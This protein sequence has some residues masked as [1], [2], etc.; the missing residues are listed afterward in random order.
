MKRFFVIVA[1]VSLIALAVLYFERFHTASADPPLGPTLVVQTAGTTVN[2]N[3]KVLNV[4][5]GCSGTASGTT[6]TLTCTGS[7]GTVTLA[8]DVTGA[9]NANTITSV[10]G[11]AFSGAAPSTNQVLGYNGSQVTYLGPM[12]PLAGGTLTGALLSNIGGTSAVPFTITG[13]A[14]QNGIAYT[15]TQPASVAGNGTSAGSMLSFTGAAGGNTSG[16]TGQTAGIGEGVSFTL[17]TGGT[18]S[19]G[20]TTGSGGNFLVI[21]GLRGS[22]GGTNGTNGS[23]IVRA[24]FTNI[25]VVFRVQNSVSTSN[26]TVADSGNVVS[27]GSVTT[28]GLLTTNLLISSTAPTIT[29]GFGTGASI[30]ANNGTGA[31]RVGVGTSSAATGIIGLPT[32]SAGWNCSCADITTN[33]A[34]VFL[35]KQTSSSTTS[36]TIG[37]FNTSAAGAAWADNDVLAVSCFAY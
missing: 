18:A 35:C 14:S 16:T 17:G 9:S 32:A 11:I 4:S 7:G 6:T 3:T 15:G 31:F 21:P 13:V 26:F 10:N 24:G 2:A 22:G 1:N 28:T 19:S 29:S 23:M 12:L 30:S 37:N 34:T 8:G 27:N 33:S 36:A 5:A 20:S 25:G